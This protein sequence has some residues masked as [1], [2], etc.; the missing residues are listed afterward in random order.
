MSADLLELPDMSD[1]T[2]RVNACLAAAHK[3]YHGYGQASQARFYE[4]V[5]QLLAPLAREL[6]RA[7]ANTQDAPK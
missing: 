3:K 5:H 2:P 1:D 4:E 7:A 6:E